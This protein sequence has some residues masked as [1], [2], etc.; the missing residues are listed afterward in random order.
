MALHRLHGQIDPA[1]Q[2]AAIAPAPAG[3]R[4]LVLATS[5]AETSLT[6]DGVRVVI[7][8]GLARRPRYDRAAGV[9]RLVTERASQAAIGQARG[10]AARQGRE[11]S[12]GCG[13][14]RRP[15]GC[16]VFDP[17]EIRRGRSVVADARLDHLGC[18]GSARAALA[19]PAPEARSRRHGRG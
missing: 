6:L 8:S 3:R 2:R 16:R 12:I 15:P 18:R 17:P 11:P 5:I 19:R 4:K 7:D 10:R 13:R 14:R 1:A 9:T